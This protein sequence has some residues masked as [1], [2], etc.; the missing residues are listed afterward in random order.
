MVPHKAAV[1][2]LTRLGV[3]Q[4]AAWRWRSTGSR[5]RSQQWMLTAAEIAAS[6]PKGMVR[7]QGLAMLFASV[8]A[9]LG[10]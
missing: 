7:A 8:A 4:S 2:S 3:V 5:V 9:H 1:R 10:R 6:G